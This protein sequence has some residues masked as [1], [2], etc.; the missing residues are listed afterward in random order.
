MSGHKIVLL[1]DTMVGKTT[2]MQQI[3]QG[4][5]QLDQYPTIAATEVKKFYKFENTQYKLS[6]WDTAGQERFRSLTPLYFGNVSLFLILFD[7]T[8]YSTFESCTSWIETVRTSCHGAKIIL[9][10]N[11]IDLKAQRVISSDQ[12]R[13]FANG[14][15]IWY[16]ECSA[17]VGTGVIKLMDKI[18][19]YINKPFPPINHYTEESTEAVHKKRKEKQCCF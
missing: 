16:V 9:I 2:L 12:A 18:C 6:F 19:E 17:Q 15:Q 4:T 8:Q 3:T 13:L 11:K 1:G 5:I 7:V 10:G 14:K